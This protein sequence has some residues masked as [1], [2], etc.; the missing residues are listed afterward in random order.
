ML[1]HLIPIP[2]ID[3]YVDPNY[4]LILVSNPLHGYHSSPDADLGFR[5]G[6]SDSD[7]DMGGLRLDDGLSFR[8]RLAGV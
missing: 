5:F 6:T 3:I 2:A 8:L 1:Y 7:V 4:G